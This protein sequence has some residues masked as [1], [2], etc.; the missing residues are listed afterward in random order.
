MRIMLEARMSVPQKPAQVKYTR[1][2][3]QEM[4]DAYGGRC[5]CCGESDS[6]LL[7]LD[8][9]HGDGQVDRKNNRRGR[10]MY[11]YLRRLGW[12]RDDY[13]LLCHNCNMARGFSGRCPHKAET[14]DGKE[15]A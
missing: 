7:A 12:P 13:R 2:V 1:K 10:V 6:V 14:L 11:V 15:S 3:K 5:E 8:H 4:V 9:I